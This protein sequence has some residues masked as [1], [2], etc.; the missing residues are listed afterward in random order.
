MQP[1]ASIGKDRS[2]ATFMSFRVVS[3]KDTEKGLCMYHDSLRL[4]INVTSV[5]CVKEAE[6][7]AIVPG[8]GDLEGQAS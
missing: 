8:P 5:A 3:Q 1:T 4:V 7:R 2:Q 6:K